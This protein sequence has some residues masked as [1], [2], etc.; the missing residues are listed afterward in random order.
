MKSIHFILESP[1]IPFVKTFKQIFSSSLLNC[2]WIARKFPIGSSLPGGDWPD[3]KVNK[4]CHTL[5]TSQCCRPDLAGARIYFLFSR[6]FLYT[7]QNILIFLSA[8]TSI[9]DSFIPL[10]CRPKNLERRW[11]NK[12]LISNHWIKVY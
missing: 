6:L 4:L 2:F 1:F 9:D 11:R 5:L 12:Q 8:N 3:P 7:S 10:L